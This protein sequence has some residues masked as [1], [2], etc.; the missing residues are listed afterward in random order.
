[1]HVK[2]PAQGGLRFKNLVETALGGTLGKVSQPPEG[3]TR[4]APEEGNQR[5]EETHFSVN[6]W[7]FECLT[8][9]VIIAVK[10]VLQHKN[11]KTA[12]LT[13]R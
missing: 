11:K 7:L 4:G 5:V 6:F 12:G 2:H 1:M 10:H 3:C 8:T 13:C 9:F